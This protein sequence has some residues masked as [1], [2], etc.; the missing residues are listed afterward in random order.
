MF[1]TNI[2]AGD[3]LHCGGIEAFVFLTARAAGRLATGPAQTEPSGLS[4]DTQAFGKLADFSRWAAWLRHASATALLSTAKIGS[5]GDDFFSAVAKAFP[6]GLVI[7]VSA[8][9]ADHGKSPKL[10]ACKVFYGTQSKTAVLA[11]NPHQSNSMPR[12][13]SGSMWMT[14]MAMGSL[15][16]YRETEVG[17]MKA[18]THP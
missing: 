9:K 4:R 16:V 6:E 18:P 14:G 7:F 11:F 2:A 15:R 13:S 1:A 10:L 5:A 8:C 17:Q 3:F 12:A